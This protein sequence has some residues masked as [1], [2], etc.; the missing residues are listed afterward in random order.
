MHFTL[1]F[2]QEHLLFVQS[3]EQ[4]KERN[5]SKFAEAM[6][7]KVILVQIVQHFSHTTHT[8][9]DH[10]PNSLKV[11]NPVSVDML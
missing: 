5:R 4:L 11:S 7:S 3:H 1:F 6:S 9:L 10:W 2:L 8:I